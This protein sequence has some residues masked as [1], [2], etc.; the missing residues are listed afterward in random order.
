MIRPR[1]TN[2]R[3]WSSVSLVAKWA[4]AMLAARLA[5]VLTAVLPGALLHAAEAAVEG[6]VVRVLAT[7][8]GRFGGCMA[9]LDVAVSEAGLDCPGN[10]VSFSCVGEHAE[11]EAAARVFD[12]LRAA[13]VA[14]KSVEM[15]V[16]DARK[17]GRF[18]YASRIKVQD[19]PHVDEDSDADG[20]LDLED[21]LPLDASETVDTDD[22]GVG[23]NADTD[24]DNDGIDDAEDTCPLN[25]AENCGSGADVSVGNTSCTG[26]RTSAAAVHLTMTGTVRAKV[27]VTD[28]RVTGYGDGQLVGTDF[29]GSIAA[30]GSDDFSI[31]GTVLTRAG[32]VSCTAKVEY[33]RSGA[34]R[35]H[36]ID[37][38]L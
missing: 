8:D 14:G 11:R 37:I 1:A 5:V 4:V 34:R 33:L 7:G 20:V 29:L 6:G 27:S 19:E 3:H 15:R 13:V 25:P 22:D 17:H 28:L 10:W 9:A 38:K 21:D 31:A 35:L 30:G 12:S 32:K 2:L 18:C 36:S 23:N 24:D 16:T 26:R